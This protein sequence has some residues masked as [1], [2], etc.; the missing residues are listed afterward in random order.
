MHVLKTTTKSKKKK[1]GNSYQS[2][3]KNQVCLLGHQGHNDEGCRTQRWKDFM[4][5]KKKMKEK[6]S[7]TKESAQLTA[8]AQD[9]ADLPYYDEAFSASLFK[10]LDIFDTGATTHMFAD[11]SILEDVVTIPPSHISVASKGGLFWATLKGSVNFHGLILRNVLHSPELTADL[12]SIGRLCDAAFVAV[13]R[14]Q[15]GVLINS[16]KRIVLRLT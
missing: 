7:S 3:L 15:D 5:Y 12:I 4:E 11:P 13:F 6:P 9:Q 2:S 8:S 1:D 14:S 10:A 16:S